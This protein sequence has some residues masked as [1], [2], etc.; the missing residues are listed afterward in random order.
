MYKTA[1]LLVP[2][3]DVGGSRLPCCPWLV[4]G[5]RRNEPSS[6][7]WSERHPVLLY[8]GPVF[9][10]VSLRYLKI[11][12]WANKFFTLLH[13]FTLFMYQPNV[14]YFNP[15]FFHW[16]RCMWF[17]YTRRLGQ[18]LELELNLYNLISV[19]GLGRRITNRRHCI[20][21]WPTMSL[22]Q[23]WSTGFLFIPLWS[24]SVVSAWPATIN[25][26]AFTWSHTH[27]SHE[28]TTFVPTS[29]ASILFKVGRVS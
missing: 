7:V 22:F 16:R 4:W 6:S 13:C 10:Q 3:W 2:G 1:W 12:G 29:I 25:K 20:A 9:L 8:W 17:N 28:P 5:S 23:P 19:T 15:C 18:Q 14:G 24:G 21:G 26:T 11:N 27:K